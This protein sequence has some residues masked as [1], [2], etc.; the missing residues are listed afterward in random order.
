MKRIVTTLLSIMICSL[1][2]F[3]TEIMKYS[4]LK[5]GMEG[6]GKTVFK[7]TNIESFNFKILGFLK[8]FSPG[9]NLIIAELDS[10]ELK[11]IGVIEGMSGSPL[12]ING[13]VIGAV[14]YGFSYSKKAIAGVTPI[15]DIIGVSKFDTPVFSIDI[16]DIKVEFNKKNYLR[17]SAFIRNELEKRVFHS[18]ERS[19]LPIKLYSSGRGINRSVDL[20][21][22]RPLFAPSQNISLKSSDILKNSKDIKVESA[23]AVAITL[24]RGDFE[25]S[26]SGTVSY[27]DGN[28]IYMFGH[29]F[30]NLGSVSFPLHKAEVVSVVP[31]YQNS[32]KLSATE[33]MIGTVTQDRFSAV[34]GELTKIPEMIP[35]K[36]FFK[37][38]NK[39]FSVEMVEHP[40]LTPAL[41]QI[42][43]SNIFQTEIQQY[44]F[45]TINIKGKIFIENEK[46]IVIDDMFSGA[47]SS[48]EFSDLLMS[49]NFFLLNNKEK[50]VKIQKMDFDFSS[51]ETLKRGVI[52]NVLI[53]KNSYFPGELIGI[54]IFVRNERGKLI[55]EEIKIKAPNLKPGSEFKILIAD[56][57]EMGKFDSKNTKSSYFP[58]KLD[59]LI[60]AINNLRKNNR[61]YIKVI[62]PE[63]GLFLKGYEYSNLPLGIKSIF[64]SGPGT[65]DSSPMKYSTIKEYQMKVSSV[66]K[67]KKI[68]TLK[69][70]ER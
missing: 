38:R 61:I 8:N 29:P 51:S 18:S 58:V 56:K 11:E 5:A 39:K 22:L 60:R 53:E 17:I 30:F 28:K 20:G 46:N 33:E 1:Y 35:L 31:S 68:F 48:G 45:N 52:S 21:V 49:I 67:G 57:T 26:A 50:R 42:S 23:E 65:D 54:K 15:E 9:K 4:D 37:N 36:I 41:T 66:I 40:L 27:M 3:T 47:N 59:S 63:K 24:I 12:Y 69:I 13:K 62:S 6:K 7:G 55:K 44:G 43:V 14:S 34:Y 19:F 25:Y 16:S 64:E 70:K 2:L 10:P 32:F